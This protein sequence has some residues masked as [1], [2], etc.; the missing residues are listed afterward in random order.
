MAFSVA[1]LGA[2]A[3]VAIVAAALIARRVFRRPS[4]N[5]LVLEA[6]KPVRS[7]E[8]TRLNEFQSRALLHPD[9]REVF[10]PAPPHKNPVYEITLSGFLK[11]Y[12]DRIAD[13]FYS[14][15]GDG[16]FRRLHSWLH[17]NDRYLRIG[18]YEVI[19]ED[20]CEHR[21]SI[22]IDPPVETR[23]TLT[24]KH[25]LTRAEGV[26][27]ALV[28]VLPEGSVGPRESRARRQEERA[29]EERRIEARRQQVA[30]DTY[31][32]RQIEALCTRSEVFRNWGDAE[33]RAKFA[34]VHYS[35]LIS[36]QKQIREEAIQLLEQRDIVGYLRRHRPDVVDIFLGRLE[37]LLIAERVDLDKRLLAAAAPASAGQVAAPK[38]AKR[39]LT[40]TQMRQLKLKNQQRTMEDKLALVKDKI[41]REQDARA[42]V[43]EQYPDLAEDEREA[44]YQQVVEALYEEEHNAKVL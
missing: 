6:P 32:A 26:I 3:F 38:P 22:R 35:A 25:F 2:I 37:A 4:T 44:M 13:A 17:V 40:E 39:K 1:Y 43:A 28:T 29:I 31:F 34:E 41:A 14:T 36:E 27:S 21:Y 33:Y 19:S 12:G 10:F 8:A 20:R 7:R 30:A 9:R 18:E 11:G 24:M 15:D 16:N 23:L 42:W 5:A